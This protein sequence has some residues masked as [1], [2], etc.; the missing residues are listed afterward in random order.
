MLHR[1]PNSAL[2]ALARQDM[3]RH[4]C[5]LWVLCG[6]GQSEARGL[7]QVCYEVY[8]VE[9]QPADFGDDHQEIDPHIVRV[10][11]SADYTS[12]QLG[13]VLSLTTSNTVYCFSRRLTMIAKPAALHSSFSRLPCVLSNVSP[14][15]NEQ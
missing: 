5:H 9:N 13:I 2:T 1:F 6:G 3:D 10:G 7:F 14:F 8:I 12:F 11:W 4:C 15:H